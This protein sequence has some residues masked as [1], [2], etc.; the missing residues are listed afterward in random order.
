[1]IRSLLGAVCGAIA[2]LGPLSLGA[3]TD[4]L[5]LRIVDVG[6]GLCTVTRVPGD[7]WMIYD[8]GHWQGRRCIQTVR[9][10]VGTD[11]IDLVVISHAD[12]DHM[13]DADDILHEFRVRQFIH[14]GFEREGTATWERM[15]DT[16]AAKV[17]HEG[18]SVRSLTTH[19][20]VPGERIQL[21]DE[22]TITL[23][24]G[25][26]LFP[27]TGLGDSERRNAGS[28]VLRL[29]YAGRSILYAGDAVGRH[30]GDPGSTCAF[31]EEILVE[32]HRS[33][34]FSLA[35]HVLIA[36]H[37][38]ADNGS[39]SCFIDAVDPEWVIFSAGHQFEHPRDSTAVRYLDAGVRLDHLLRTDRGDD[40]DGDEWDQG[41]VPGCT[42]GRGD[43]D[44]QVVIWEDGTMT[45][46][47]VR[48]SSGC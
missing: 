6:P 15:M 48:P 35:A 8:A 4:S 38:G 33:N 40:E 10:L 25:W 44:V 13:G 24:G 2:L 11:E 46:G 3:Q 32:R 1:M 22:V 17:R 36:P 43:D 20:L 16:V 42:D 19:P 34:V 14:T 26:G 39:S 45:V 18:L 37:H 31:A 9:E 41:A 21:G 47:Y 5:L 27:G 29:D 7:G 30:I 23:L 28:I 12:S